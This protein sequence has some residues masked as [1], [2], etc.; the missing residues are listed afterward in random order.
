MEE[1]EVELEEEEDDDFIDYSPAVIDLSLPDPLA[2]TWTLAQPLLLE[3][4]KCSGKNDDALVMLQEME[5]TH[6]AMAK[7]IS[8]KAI[9]A[10]PPPPKHTNKPVNSTPKPKPPT[11][12]PKQPPFPDSALDFDEQNN[13]YADMQDDELDDEEYFEDEEYVD[14]GEEDEE[15]TNWDDY[16][17]EID[18]EKKVDGET[19]VDEE[20]QR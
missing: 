2:H 18:A 12:G 4:M 14:S 6:A 16:D 19:K 20:R 11:A 15:N 8:T 13:K 1:E 7:K 3:N 5:A 10:P 17:S 9:T